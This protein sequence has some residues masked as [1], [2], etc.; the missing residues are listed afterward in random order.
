MRFGRTLKNNT[1]PPWKAEYID[2]EK[3]KKLLRESP[4]VHGSSTGSQEDDAEWTEDD[5]S[6]FV[7]ELVNVQL[8]KVHAFQAKTLQRLQDETLECEQKLEPLG[9][10]TKGEAETGDANGSKADSKPKL[11]DAER[12][13]VL[14]EVLKILDGIT[15]ETNELERY[16]RVNYSGFLKATKKHDR[17]R[18]NSYRV[19]PLMQ[20]RLAALPFYS[21]DYT[22][23]VNRLSAMYSFVRQ[24]LDG[25]DH[26][27][28]SFAHDEAG[29]STYTSYKCKLP[30]KVP[31]LP[32]SA[33]SRPQSGST[34]KTCSKSKPSSSAASQSWSTTLKRPKSL[35]A[36][37]RIRR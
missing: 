2:Y 5:E 27:G 13:K 7:E 25:K 28:L 17:K 32:P 8:E 20:V 33:D 19:R 30:L 22:P 24:N 18:G 34:P 3:L 23:M 6:A 11:S 29:T 10:G 16:S 4:S 35:K 31:P 14:E 12:K 21:E 1:Y 36:A 15:K 37:S 26:E 9:V